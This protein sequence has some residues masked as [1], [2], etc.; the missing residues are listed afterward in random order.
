[1][2]KYI[3]LPP[4]KLE[5]HLQNFLIE[6][7]SVSGVNTFVRNEK[8]FERYYVFKDFSD[9]GMSAAKIVGTAYHRALEAFFE[10]WRD[11]GK[12][13][14]LDQLLDIAFRE[15]D[16]IELVDFKVYVK[17]T[18]IEVK[19]QCQKHINNL[20]NQFLEEVD[21][22]L[23][24]IQEVIFVEEMM[25]EFITLAD[26]DIPLPIKIISDLIYINKSGELCGLDHKSKGIYTKEEERDLHFAYQ[27][28]GYDRA[29]SIHLMRKE[30][31]ALRKKYPKI[32]DGMKWFRFYE[33]KYT[34]NRNGDPQI[35]A[36]VVDIE[37]TRD[38][39]ESIL[40]EPVWRIITAV[41]DPDYV[42]LMNPMDFFEDGG[43]IVDFWVK[44]HLEDL[45]AFQNLDEK[46]KQI[47]KRRKSRIK[48]TALEKVPKSVME[49]IT[50]SKKFVSF[51]YDDMADK[52]KDELIKLVLRSFNINS[53]IREVIEGYSCDTYLLRVGVGTKISKVSGHKLDIAQALGVET[54]RVLP[55]LVQWGSGSYVAIEVNKNK[56]ERKPAMLSDFPQDGGDILPIGVDNFG[57]IISWDLN[58]SSTPHFMLSGASGSGKSY[59]LAT[60]IE[61]ALAQGIKVTI[62]DPKND[63]KFD[64]YRDKCEVYTE[65]DDI[66]AF[67][68]LKVEEMDRIFKT[69]D[70]SASKE[71]IVFDEVAD[72][73]ARQTK[74]KRIEVVEGHYADGREKIKNIK[75]KDF[76]TL[77]LNLLILG[78]KARSA[79]IHLVLA[80][81]RFSTK[82]LTGDVKANFTIRL[83]LKS[84]KA[85][86]SMV[87]L[88]EDGAEKLAGN[89]DGLLV[90]PSHAG[91]VRIQCYSR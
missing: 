54:V 63:D 34:K 70:R 53:E 2:N 38:L 11:A 3:K 71:I 4:E 22:Y 65:L 79:G 47:L 57:E 40:F 37:A 45:S 15:L 66:E 43:Q 26:T 1:M 83:A 60:M 52:P 50:G 72:C 44:T 24:D 84:A 88:D 56:D 39:Y 59:A 68:E 10:T 90:S 18:S 30:Y 76:K 31:A 74:E 33:N 51:N 82:I 12:K 7:W 67:V 20:I 77:E 69:R 16:K 89:G 5:A 86:D 25:K 29:V 87:M 23:D 14:N 13:L 32:K 19:D 85:V 81:Q 91:T 64:P 58:D 49:S 28:T 75:D 61:V 80:A 42:Y 9:S 55:D 6:H 41:Q 46:Q 62:L 36:Y 8:A 73:L 17:K 78:Q 21:I 35:R 27:S 48:K